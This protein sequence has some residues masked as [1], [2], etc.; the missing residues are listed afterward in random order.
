MLSDEG[1][2][3]C[4]PL[5]DESGVSKLEH[6]RLDAERETAWVEEPLESW[7]EGCLPGPALPPD[8]AFEPFKVDLGNQEQGMYPGWV[9][10]REI[11]V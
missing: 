9:R 11:S 3:R 4:G 6:K 7:F 10:F 1:P 8:I 2:P 5:D